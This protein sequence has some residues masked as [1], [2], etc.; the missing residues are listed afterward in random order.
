[1]HI[2]DHRQHKQ[3]KRRIKFRSSKRVVIVG[4]LVLM[5]A[6]V[7]LIT[8]RFFMP[9]PTIKALPS[10]PSYISGNMNIA[11]PSYGQSAV[12][13]LDSG[14][15]NSS[16]DTTARPIASIAKTLTA[17]AVLRKKPLG[18]NEQGPTITLSIAD[19]DIYDKYVSQDGSVVK[20]AAGQVITER[21][22]LEALML[23]SANNMA[24]TLSTWAFGSVRQY[25]EYANT[26]ALSLGMKSTTIT[27][28]SGF[29]P[30]TKSTASDL[31][32]LGQ[33]A[34]NDPVLSEIVG[35]KKAVIPV[36]GEIFSTN[37]L[38]GRDGINGIK[39][40]TTDQAGGC[41]LV[42]A[43]RTMPDGTTKTLIAAIL[44]APDKPKAMADSLPLLKSLENNYIQSRVIQKD[45]KLGFYD[46][47]W[48][49]R[50]SVLAANDLNAYGWA[51]TKYQATVKLN[52]LQAP[53]TQGQVVGNVQVVS[54]T[55]G[56]VVLDQAIQ[57]PSFSWRFKRAA[58]IW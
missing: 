10:S 57:E 35:L 6:Y 16:S 3:G 46:V 51:G 47:P 25:N 43:T 38:L 12:G 55:S 27:D 52:E 4:L 14:L 53:A 48:Q 29:L 39:T 50:V 54:K 45:Q 28:P 9:L 33:A 7:G 13:S 22:A 30:T 44:G 11:W 23:P 58:K 15:L 36:Q 34:M 42:S 21:Q 2:I 41:Y 56:D 31:V 1:M 8:T 32:L 24:E 5:L 17:L 18:V 20:V 26:L 40:G 49:G 37:Y 19:V